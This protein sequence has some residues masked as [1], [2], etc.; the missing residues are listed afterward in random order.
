MLKVVHDIEASNEPA[1]GSLLDEIMR[2]GARQM[3]AA[4]RQ[5]EVAAYVEQFKDE[6][7]EHGRRLVVRNGFHAEREV[8]TAAGAIPVRAPRVNDKRVDEATGERQRFGSAMLSAWARKSRRLRRCCRCCTCTAYR[9][10]TSP[11]R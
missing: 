4:A 8:T 10:R 7:D 3:L 6:L 9:P 1:G 2:D 5:A 11:R